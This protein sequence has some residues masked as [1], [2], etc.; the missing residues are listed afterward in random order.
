MLLFASSFFAK[1]KRK[2]R[3]GR[4]TLRLAFHKKTKNNKISEGKRKKGKKKEKGKRRKRSKNY[5]LFM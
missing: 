3:G 1:Q 2:K 4:A 5:Y